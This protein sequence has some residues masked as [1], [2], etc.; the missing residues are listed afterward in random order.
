[1]TMA[2]SRLHPLYAR[3]ALPPRM[4][5]PMAHTVHPLCRQAAEEAQ[6]YIASVEE[7]QEEIGRGKMFGV[8]VVK[9][10][11]GQLAFLAAYSG[12]LAERNDWPYF[13]PAVFD[14]QQPDGYFKREE[15]VI[16]DI[17]RQVARLQQSPRLAE[18][19][20]ALQKAKEEEDRDISEWKAAMDAAKQRRDDIRQQKAA[21]STPSADGSSTSNDQRE[22]QFSID[23]RE[24]QSSIFNLQSTK[25][26]INLQS[27]EEAS[28]EELTRE[29]QWMK[30]ELRRKRQ[31]HA[32]VIGALQAE[33]ATL[34]KEIAALRTL[35]RQKSEALQHW[36]FE[37]F[38][39]LNARG[40]SRHLLSIFAETTM[41]EPPS[42]AGECCAP[43]LLQYAFAH[44]L[45]PVSIAEFWWGKSPEGDIRHH[46]Q[47]YP[48]CRGKCLPILTHMLQGLE[49]EGD[50]E[51]TVTAT[52]DILFEDKW[53][54]VVCKPAGMLSVPGKT[55]EA[56]VYDFARSH[57]PD[58]DGPLMVHRLDMA[59]SG[60]LVIAK[61][62]EVHEQLQRQFLEHR[63]EKAYIARLEH[64]LPA[65]VPPLGTISLPIRP[66]LLDRPRQTIDRRHGKT[67]ITRYEVAEG[68]LIRLQPLTGRTH[69]LR[70]HCAHPEGLGTPIKGDTLYGHTTDQ[71]NLH[72]A[73]QPAFH[74][75]D[76]PS[77]HT[78]D[79]PSL[80]IDRLYLHAECL[81]FDHPVTGQRMTFQ[82]PPP[83]SFSEV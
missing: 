80:T 65:S 17:N 15:A 68:S 9:T 16:S 13:V 73:D 26:R 77:L 38:Q 31:R 58:A 63:I 43:K 2:D 75:T 52:P 59:T 60:L 78:T 18:L 48:A 7:W 53:L 56:S 29:S 3:Y 70:I 32:A 72:T 4:N 24:N 79:Q 27:T 21:Q 8:L 54:M 35:R 25:G 30:A 40:E 39:M 20:E 34:E 74:A 81:S 50:T 83:S 45:R 12:L 71:P 10:Q 11:E 62:K 44:H 42:G 5:D 67:A 66:A 37:H 14:F 36:L 33:I 28:E 6:R 69:Q 55:A 51:K 23:Q 76:R 47:Y 1:M 41:R 64:P 19:H 46:L 61:T 57:C 49:V 82:C 22:N